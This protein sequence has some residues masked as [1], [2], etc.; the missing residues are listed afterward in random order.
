MTHSDNDTELKTTKL[1]HFK[2]SDNTT[3][4]M[5]HVGNVLE[6]IK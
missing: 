2:N 1:V 4:H 5:F 6:L 3:K